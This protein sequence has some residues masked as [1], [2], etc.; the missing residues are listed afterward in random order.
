MVGQGSATTQLEYTQ[1]TDADARNSQNPPGEDVNSGVAGHIVLDCRRSGTHGTTRKSQRM[2]LPRAWDLIM[3][4]LNLT[5][6][7]QSYGDIELL[8]CDVRG[9]LLVRCFWTSVS[10]IIVSPQCMACPARGAGRPR[11]FE[12]S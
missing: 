7:R 6:L 3:D 8:V 1:A 12:W 10:S 2:T 11:V 4:A 5:N 9:R